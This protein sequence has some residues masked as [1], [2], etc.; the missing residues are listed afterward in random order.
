[1]ALYVPHVTINSAP[2]SRLWCVCVVIKM[3]KPAIEMHIGIKV[4]RNRCF[5]LS[6]KYAT[7]IEKPNAAAQ[8]GTECSWVPI[9]LYP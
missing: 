2:Y 9:V 1:M 7:I 3:Q 5:S 6:E 4:N 8:G